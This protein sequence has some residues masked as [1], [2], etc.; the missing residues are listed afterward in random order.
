[1][2]FNIFDLFSDAPEVDKY[3]QQR[4]DE[5]GM[6]IDEYCNTYGYNVDEILE[7]KSWEDED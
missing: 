2:A 5:Q 4:M 1:M 7:E 6:S 3:H